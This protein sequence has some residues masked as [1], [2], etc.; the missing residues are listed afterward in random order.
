MREG[1]FTRRCK[2]GSRRLNRIGVL[3]VFL[4]AAYSASAQHCPYDGYFLIV[5]RVTDSLG[6]PVT[7]ARLELR[8]STVVSGIKTTEPLFTKEFLPV[9]PLLTDSLNLLPNKNVLEQFCRQCHFLGEGYY[10]VKL[11]QRER[12]PPPSNSHDSA[13]TAYHFEVWKDNKKTTI[14]PAQAYRLCWSE[15]KWDRIQPVEVGEF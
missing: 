3:V 2:S 13:T 14:P 15:G 8:V 4:L 7:G 6:K 1:C 12:R 11:E 5:V 9:K 10:A